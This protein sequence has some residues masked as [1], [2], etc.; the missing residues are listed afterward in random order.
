MGE[1]ELFQTFK[2]FKTSR[3]RPYQGPSFNVG[4]ER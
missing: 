2:P 3:L 4:F 1:K